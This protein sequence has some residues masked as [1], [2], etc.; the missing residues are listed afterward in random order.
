MLDVDK[1][2]N[3]AGSCKLQ[4]GTGIN[5]ILPLAKGPTSISLLA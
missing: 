1:F 4:Q 5:I 2:P 3:D